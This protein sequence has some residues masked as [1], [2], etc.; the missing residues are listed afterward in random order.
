VER[1]DLT[2]RAMIRHSPGIQPCSPLRIAVLWL[3]P[4]SRYSYPWRHHLMAREAFMRV[5]RS[6]RRIA[7]RHKCKVP[8]R[9][10]IWKSAISKETAEAQNLS[11]GGIYFATDSLLRVGTVIELTVNMPEEITGE[12][13]SEWLCSGHVV[14]IQPI[15]LPCGKLGV[16]VQFDCYEVTR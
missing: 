14:R 13:T 1:A 5:I 11:E 6:D 8:V 12:P 15:N 7:L 16:G 2:I 3:L 10:H 9:F 4:P